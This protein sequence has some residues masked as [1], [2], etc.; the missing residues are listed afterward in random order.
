MPIT[1]AMRGEPLADFLDAAVDAARLAGAVIRD[2]A[3]RRASIVIERKTIND[4]V[5][6]VDKSAERAIIG[7]LSARFPTHAFKAEES[8]EAG[9][10]THTWLIDPLDGTT[11]FLHGFPHY[12][13][14][15]A[16]R[17]HDTVMVGVVHDPT[18]GRLFT[19]IRGQGA[20]LDGAPIRVAERAGL[21]EAIVGTGLPYRN[22]GYLD[23][24][25]ASLREIMQRC[26]GVRRPGAAAL[27]LA[28]VS[29]GWTDGHWERDLNAWDVGAASLLVEEAGGVV[30]TFAG[31]AGFLDSGHIVVGTPGVH[32]ELL[33]VLARYPA[34]AA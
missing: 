24:Y 16:L 30:S 7:A 10:S 14:S 12:C 15:I 13:V 6:I 21:A 5:S 2:G 33:G 9:T 20:Y 22:W 1:D 28:Y 18:S 34:L 4:F 17:I 23:D 8:G 19:A 31:D 27:D 11:N 25:M 26:A 3:A 32:A 29:A